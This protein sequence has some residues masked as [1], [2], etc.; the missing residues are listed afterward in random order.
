MG[1]NVKLSLLLLINYAPWHKNY[2]AVEVQL[3]SSSPRQE[4]YVIGELH[5]LW[6]Q[7]WGKQNPNRHSL[8]MRLFHHMRVIHISAPTGLTNGI[9]TPTLSFPLSHQ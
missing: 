6:L 3:N 9:N 1:H 4:M 5:D 2:L 7:A 8:H